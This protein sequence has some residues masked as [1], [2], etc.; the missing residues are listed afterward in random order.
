MAKKAYEHDPDHSEICNNLGIAQECNENLDDAEE[1][2][3]RALDLNELNA[4]AANNLG[5]LYEKK[6][7]LYPEQSETYRSEAIQAWKERLRI[8]IE[9]DKSTDAATTHLRQLG[10][11]TSEIERLA[12]EF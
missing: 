4:A 1:A 12:R 3:V 8:C 10:L 6:M 2:Y 7:S 5:Y 9:L 11:S